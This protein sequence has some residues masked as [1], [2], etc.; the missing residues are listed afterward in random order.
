[1]NGSHMGKERL[2]ILYLTNIPAPYTVD[3]Y[4][5]LGQYVNLT[6][7][8][9]R[10]TAENREEKWFSAKEMRFE[11]VFLDGKRYGDE[12]AVCF[13]VRKYLTRD[14]D[15]VIVGDY[16][17][18]TGMI[19][20]HRLKRKKIPYAIHADGALLHKES[21]LKRMIKKR[22]FR[23][24]C[25]FFSSGEAT[26]EYFRQYV[27]GILP[28]Y[29][30]PFTSLREADLAARALSRR[31]RVGMR[32]TSLFTQEYIVLFVGSIS[33]RKGVDIL[34]RVAA[35]LPENVGVHIVGGDPTPD[36]CAIM[37]QTSKK[38]VAFHSFM[39]KVQV[40]EWM[41]LADLFVLPTREDIWG[42][43]V[44]EAM[45][46]GLPVLT[47]DRC[48]SGYEL[49]ERGELI[50][51]EEP[52]VWAQKIMD[53]LGDEQKLQRAGEFGLQ[54][55]KEYT[56]EAMARRYF[57]AIAEICSGLERDKPEK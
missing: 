14:F 54:R 35:L 16:S 44:N 52:A 29:R 30:Y 26:D 18:P 36:L 31:E 11:A 28:V 10:K 37:E 1:M 6:V 43:V 41:R 23:R 45:S 12:M 15:L 24:A 47:S 42:L 22:L 27:K 20:I 50:D 34:V 32:D 48:G 56:I 17:S 13:G 38:N 5:E 4:N 21:A 39:P 40:L 53:L 49:L 25:G 7:L 46:Q 51:T 57:N 3:F 9:E 19:A 2:K 8:F 55:M 33:K